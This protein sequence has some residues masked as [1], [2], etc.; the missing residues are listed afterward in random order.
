[1][2]EQVNEILGVSES[3]PIQEREKTFDDLITEENTLKV[4]ANV[5]LIVGIIS[6]LILLF[7]VAIIQIQIK[8]EYSF[9]DKTETIF[10]ASGFV[11]TIGTFFSSIA[12]WAFLRVIGNISI[13]LKELKEN[14]LNL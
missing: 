6:S 10:N 7:T 12:L 4:I 8:G 3:S 9:E 1:M 13:T 5:I 11:I 14:K 2:E